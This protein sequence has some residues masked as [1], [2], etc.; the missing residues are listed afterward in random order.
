[1]EALTFLCYLWEC[2]QLRGMF[3]TWKI[4]KADY[5]VPGIF[6]RIT[7]SQ[8]DQPVALRGL[9]YAGQF[10]SKSMY[11]RERECVSACMCV[12]VYMCV[13][14]CVFVWER[15]C[16]RECVCV[17]ERECERV[18]VCVCVCGLLFIPWTITLIYK[19]KSSSKL[20]HTW[21]WQSL[22][23]WFQICS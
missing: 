13:C 17:C 20:I 23:C 16:M 22:G 3:T 5:E 1:M 21:I 12:C 2:S 8:T 4:N 7:V 15:E 19:E 14:L 9:M 11:C 18:C 6:P 10:D